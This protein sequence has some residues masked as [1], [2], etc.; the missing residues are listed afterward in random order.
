MTSVSRFALVM[1]GGQVYRANSGAN[2][3]WRR[4]L[5]GST[6]QDQF[7]EQFPTLVLHRRSPEN[8]PLN[9][10]LAALVRKLQD[11]TPNTAPGSSTHGGFQ[12]DTNFL[13]MDHPA[14]KTLQQ[15]IHAPCRPTP[16][17]FPIELTS[18]PKNVDARS[19][20]GRC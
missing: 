7:I 10:E 15:Q 5:T 3:R 16:P 18:A 1:K 14:V 11:T 12:T 6:T 19:G 4:F 13:Y 17:L 2:D 8:G 20:A 9:A